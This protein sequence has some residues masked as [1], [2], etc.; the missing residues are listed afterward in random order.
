MPE[1]DMNPG[2]IALTL[3]GLLSV[4]K[5][6]RRERVKPSKPALVAP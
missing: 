6:A 3:T 4:F 1:L 5:L 2:H